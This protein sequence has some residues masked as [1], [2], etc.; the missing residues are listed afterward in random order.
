MATSSV[1]V[2]VTGTESIEHNGRVVE[3]FRVEADR[4]VAW[5]TSDGRVLRQEVDLPLLGRLTLIDEPF[6]Q[7]Q[8]YQDGPGR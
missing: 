8:A 1:L 6:D 4:A 2:R 3:A 7:Q 5:V